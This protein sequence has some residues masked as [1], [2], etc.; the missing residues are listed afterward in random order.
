MGYG[1]NTLVRILH[2]P[3]DSQSQHNESYNK[4]SKGALLEL[5]GTGGRDLRTLPSELF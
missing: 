4:R 1:V 3:D 5:N 2:F